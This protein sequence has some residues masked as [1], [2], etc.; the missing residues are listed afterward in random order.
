MAL[1]RPGPFRE[2]KLAERF[3]DGLI[4]FFFDA[5]PLPPDHFSWLAGF[6]LA[7]SVGATETINQYSLLQD[8]RLK[9]GKIARLEWIRA[10]N[11]QD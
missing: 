4:Y 8:A 2:T 10:A 3:W 7:C 6:W 11:L 1:W 5:S 9:A